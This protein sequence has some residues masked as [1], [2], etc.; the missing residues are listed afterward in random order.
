MALAGILAETLSFMGAVTTDGVMG[1]T[2]ADNEPFKKLDRTG[3][4]QLFK[5][6]H[7]LYVVESRPFQIEVQEST[8]GLLT[9][10]AESTSDPHEA[11]PPVSGSEL[12]VVLQSL[13][14]DIDKKVSK[15]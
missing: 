7:Y 1:R 2:T 13:I 12:E 11:I 15:W 8:R 6:S 10:H 4:G 14:H 3:Q 9:A 5:V